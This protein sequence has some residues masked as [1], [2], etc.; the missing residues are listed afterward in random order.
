LGRYQSPVREGKKSSAKG[1]G[2]PGKTKKKTFYRRKEDENTM[3]TIV[4]EVSARKNVF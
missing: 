1:K 4:G 3:G 2:A